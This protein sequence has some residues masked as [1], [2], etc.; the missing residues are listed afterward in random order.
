MLLVILRNIAILN[1]CSLFS[2]LV[3]YE[4]QLEP[5]VVQEQG[6]V[7]A[8]LL[9]EAGDMC[10]LVWVVCCCCLGYFVSVKIIFNRARRA[11]G[12]RPVSSSKDANV[13][14]SSSRRSSGE[15]RAVR[16]LLVTAHPDDECMFFSPSLLKLV[17]TNAI[18]HLLCLSSGTSAATAK[19]YLRSSKNCPVSK[20]FHFKQVTELFCE[21]TLYG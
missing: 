15:L 14:P 13:S 2:V 6:D 5:L 8:G 7:P 3:P 11:G 16:A 10:V 20:H 12:Y 9:C 4:P 18:V 1:I 21:H 17:E 19:S